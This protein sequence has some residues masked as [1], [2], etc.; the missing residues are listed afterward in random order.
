MSTY[1]DPL[2]TQLVVD[3]L[4]QQKTALNVRKISKGAGVTM[5]KAYATCMNNSNILAVDPLLVGFG[6]YI[7]VFKYHE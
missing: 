7:K 5:A 1:I 4:K 3:Y 6:G 2:K